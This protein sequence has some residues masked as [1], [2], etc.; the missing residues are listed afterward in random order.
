[1]GYIPR[2]PSSTLLFCATRSLGDLAT[3][4]AELDVMVSIL[5]GT[6]ESRLNRALRERLGLTYG[7]FGAFI[8]RR[9][10]NALMFCARSSTCGSTAGRPLLAAHRVRAVERLALRWRPRRARAAL[11]TAR[12]ASMMVR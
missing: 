9:G 8:R 1:V 3:S 5:G 6:S 7:A 11:A 12:R 4:T 10:G 2:V